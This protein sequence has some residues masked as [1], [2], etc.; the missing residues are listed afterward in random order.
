MQTIGVARGFGD[1]DLRLYDSN[2]YMKPFISAYPEVHILAS[3][4]SYP[5]KP[6]ANAIRSK[7]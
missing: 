1:H 7:I 6:Y 4:I 5:I 2:I 3:T